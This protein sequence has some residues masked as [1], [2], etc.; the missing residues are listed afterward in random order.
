[1][2]MDT[3]LRVCVDRVLADDVIEE[4]MRRS[5]E[6]NPNNA[7]PLEMAVESQWLWKPGQ[8]LRVR[9]LDGDSIVHDKVAA[10]AHQWRH[11]ANI[12]FDFGNYVQAEIR[13]S[14][15]L[16]W[17]S[18]S[19]VGT[20]ALMITDQNQPTM[21][22][23]WLELGTPDEVYSGVVLHEFGHA[24]G[25]IHEHQHPEH[26][27]PWDKTAVY[28]YYQGPPNYWTK[29]QVDH[30]ILSKYSEMQTQFSKFDPKSIMLYPIPNEHTLGDWSVDW[31]NFEL[32]ETDR[33]FIKSVY[34]FS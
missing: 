14:F 25:C 2:K 17:Q 31:E 23:G 7:P 15:K 12:K 27:I 5:V 19:W 33:E 11:H 29:Q 8:V 16:K 18:W 30:N 22:F 26:G 32:S 13:I 4:A 34:P 10:V 20:K 28:N 3:G 24:L 6:V 21:N 1:M 9:F